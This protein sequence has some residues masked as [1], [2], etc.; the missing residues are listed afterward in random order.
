LLKQ[1]V[2]ERIRALATRK[3]FLIHFAQVEVGYVETLHRNLPH[4]SAKRLLE[5]LLAFFKALIIKNAKQFLIFRK[6]S[7]LM[8]TG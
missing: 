1:F 2:F 3:R 7:A 5:S 8:L 6:N 4:D